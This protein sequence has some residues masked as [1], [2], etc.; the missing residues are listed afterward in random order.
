VAD[1][2]AQI[3]FGFGTDPLMDHTVKVTLI[4]TD[5][6]EKKRKPAVKDDELSESEMAGGRR[7]LFRRIVR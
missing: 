5:F 2:E 4:A 7:P 6:S 1:S 3:I